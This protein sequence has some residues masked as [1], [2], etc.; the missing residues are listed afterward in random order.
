MFR[1]LFLSCMV[2][3]LAVSLFA[4]GTTEASSSST[5]E[6]GKTTLTYVTFLNPS[7]PAPRSVAQNE[8]L[9]KHI[10]AKQNVHILQPALLR[11][12]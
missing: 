7:D 5:S 3:V 12:P 1:K 9:R 2:L 4:S 6:N 11:A 10:P 8:Q